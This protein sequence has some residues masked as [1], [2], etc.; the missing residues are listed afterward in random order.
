[1]KTEIKICGITRREDAEY[2]VE[3]GA[4]YIGVVLVPSSKR[5]VDMKLLAELTDNLP[6]QK[7]GVFADADLD[8]IRQAVHV[9]K[10][11]I[12]QLHGKESAEFAGQIKDVKVWKATYEMDFPAERLICDAIRGG[13]GMFGDHIKA[14]QLARVKT[15][16]LAGG[17][18][19]DNAVSLIEKVRPTGIDLSSG[20]EISP[21]IKDHQKI[22][23][24]FSNMK[25]S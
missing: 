12:V 8:F 25:G 10:L 3:C 19:P 7:V 14:A 18:T 11:D 15:V 6:C 21:G 24:L 2:A 17:I 23:Q 22:K 4:D 9:G 5:F 20:V 13:S 16:M 1:M